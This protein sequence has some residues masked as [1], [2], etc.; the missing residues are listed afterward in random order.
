MRACVQLLGFAI[1]IALLTWCASVAFSEKNRAQQQKL[2]DAPWTDVALLILL[3]LASLLVNSTA[4][5]SMLR[6]V[7]RIS[8]GRVATVNTIATTLGYLPFKLSLLFRAAAHNRQDGVPLLTIGAWIGN[9]GV[10]MLAT[11]GPAIGASMWRG[12]VDAWWWVTALGGTIFLCTAIV[13][14]ARLFSHQRVWGGLESRVLGN[15]AGSDPDQAPGWK[16][17]L[18]RSELLPRVHEGIRMLAQPL[19]VFGGAAV[20]ATD[21]GIQSTRF[22]IAARIVGLELPLDQAIEAASAYFVIGALSPAGT[23]GFRE[24]VFTMLRSESFAVV[25]LTV[26]AVEMVVTLVCAAPAA[27]ALRKSRLAQA[28]PPSSSSP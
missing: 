19:A 17:A 6:P 25:V 23:L 28:V 20:R 14:V 8:F 15:A 5:W 7:R 27:W 16:R 13:F 1:G 9:V 26:S 3:S 22:I 21:I 10:V 11:I 4:F 18:R 2:A 24:G 12:K